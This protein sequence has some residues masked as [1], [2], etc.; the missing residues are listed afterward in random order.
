M[1]QIAFVLGPLTVRWYGVMAALGF[2]AA[3]LV[4][5]RNRKFADLKPEQVSDLMLYTIVAG[6]GGARLFYVIQFWSQFK[7]N[8]FEIV[9]IDHGG[10]V[11]YGGFICATIVVITYCHKKKL[12]IIKVLDIVGPGL[13]LGHAFGRVGCFM[14]GCCF[15]KPGNLPWCFVAP[16]GTHPGQKYPEIA[17]HPVQLYETAGNLIIFAILFYFAGKLKKG[18]NFSLYL[19]M[20]GAL[21]FVDEFFRGDHS[22]FLFGMFTQAQVIG[23]VLIPIGTALFFYFKSRKNDL[24]PVD[25]KC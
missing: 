21:R 10:L 4:I 11:F 17:L 3:V 9:R 16:A 18:M 5:Q 24:E 6:I 22:D 19:I 13:A 25:K 8:L 2:L 20:Y 7:N 23:I 1:H 15:G 12:S 14:N